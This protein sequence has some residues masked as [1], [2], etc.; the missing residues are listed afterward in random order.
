MFC[1]YSLSPVEYELVQNAFFTDPN[2]QS[3]WF[4]YRWLLGRGVCLCLCAP[5]YLFLDLSMST[6]AIFDLTLFPCFLSSGA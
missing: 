3:A 5:G 4:Y 6:R 1:I 2:D